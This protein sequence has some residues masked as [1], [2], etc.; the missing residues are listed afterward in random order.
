MI[1]ECVVIVIILLIISVIFLRAKRYR[2]ALSTFPLM[3]VPF[4]NVAVSQILR[5]FGESYTSTVHFWTNVVAVIISSAW[6]VLMAFY[7]ERKSQMLSYLTIAIAF[8]VILALI[9]VN[10]K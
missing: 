1:V 9:L 2:W 5:L 10:Y 8:N 7:F 3:I 4:S 6:V